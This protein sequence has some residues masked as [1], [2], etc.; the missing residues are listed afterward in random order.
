MKSFLFYTILLYVSSGQQACIVV[1]DLYS[2]I[3][4]YDVLITFSP[5]LKST[6]LP[7]PTGRDSQPQLHPLLPKH[8]QQ[9][10]A[11]MR[12]LAHSVVC[13]TNWYCTVHVCSRVIFCFSKSH[14]VHVSENSKFGGITYG[15]ISSK[16]RST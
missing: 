15:N 5:I 3:Y 10:N 16:K 1:G 6:N 2:C 13:A 11:C 4:P 14:E 9:R 8:L 12:V 7:T